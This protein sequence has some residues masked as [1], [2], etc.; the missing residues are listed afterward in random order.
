MEL[1]IS[2]KT[3]LAALLGHPVSHSKSPAMHNLSFSK[4][5]IDC[6]YLCFEVWEDNLKEAVAAMRAF[7]VIGFNVTMPNKKNV[8]KYLDEI[9]KD[10]ELIG[11]VNTVKNENGRLTGYN[12]DGIGFVKSLDDAGVDY[13]NK[14]IIICGAGGAGRA[15]SVAL[16]LNGAG[17]LIIFDVYPNAAKELAE[18]VNANTN[19]KAV[20]Y[21]YDED[22]LA[23]E[24]ASSPILINCTGLGMHPNEN[25]SVL[26]KQG[27]ITKSH[28]VADVI[29]EPSPT[30][31]LALAKSAG[32][33]TIDGLGMVYNQ[34]A[35]AFKIW[36][37]REMPLDYV[38][39]K[40]S[41]N[42]KERTNN[43]TKA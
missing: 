3:R 8:M 38:I 34:G 7:N 29:Y 1:N 42:S 31:L 23:K 40:L 30:R 20:H 21:A 24:T 25:E 4:L 37:G 27:V 33:K 18:T 5:G 15:V 28:V 22:L 17:E 2:G 6:V 13:K 41:D 32:A 12:T 11:A 39:E 9:S 36:M 43:E 16:S 35:Y 19:A 14:K 26:T 10:A